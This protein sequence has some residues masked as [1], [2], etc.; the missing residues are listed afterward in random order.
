MWEKINMS[1][2][3]NNDTNQRCRIRLIPPVNGKY[4]N[5]ATNIT[6]IHYIASNLEITATMDNTSIAEWFNNYL[7]TIL[8][9]NSHY[10]PDN[11]PNIN[12]EF[13]NSNTLYIKG[14]SID[15]MLEIVEK[16]KR[17]MYVTEEYIASDGILNGIF[18]PIYYRDSID[19]NNTGNIVIDTNIPNCIRHIKVEAHIDPIR[20]QESDD[21]PITDNITPGILKI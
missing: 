5:P 13:N 8:D 16:F 10:I 18:E 6:Y 7:K 15:L 14:Q 21:C 19:T 20:T 9:L 4:Y 3:N 11:C 17:C 1:I 2:E 12:I